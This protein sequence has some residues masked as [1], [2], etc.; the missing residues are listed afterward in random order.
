MGLCPYAREQLQTVEEKKLFGGYRQ[1]EKKVL[2]CC[3]GRYPKA[4]RYGEAIVQD[5]ATELYCRWDGYFSSFG[6]RRVC[7]YHPDCTHNIPNH[8]TDNRR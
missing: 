7:R 5:S 2:V 3:S 6:P 1:V 8:L 4:N